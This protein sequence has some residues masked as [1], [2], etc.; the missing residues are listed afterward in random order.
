M[1]L[2][3]PVRVVVVDDNPTHLVSITNGLARAGVPC[4]SHWYDTQN[5]KLTPPAPNEGYPHLRVLFTDLNILEMTGASAEPKN[6]AAVLISE[7]LQPIVA[8]T[9]GPY[10]V[11]LWT[12]TGSKADDVSPLIIQRI[13]D[14]SLGTDRRPAP[15]LVNIVEKQAFIPEKNDA[16]DEALASLFRQSSE[17]PKIEESISRAILENA[18][19]RA[20]SSWE[21]RA[22]HA[23]AQTINNIYSVSTF[24]RTEERD[25]S[26][27]FQTILTKIAIEAAGKSAK[28]DPPRALDDGL[29]D[30]FI[31]K[32]QNSIGMQSYQDAVNAS[33]GAA[34]NVRAPVLTAESRLALNTSL[35]VEKIDL[36][37]RHIE[38]GL[39]IDINT[40]DALKKLE[41]GGR[42]KLLLDELIYNS[43]L[44]DA[45]IEAAKAANASASDIK[46]LQ[47]DLEF[48]TANKNQILNEARI[49]AIEIGADCDHAQRKDRTI[50][51]LLGAEIPSDF[52]RFI[53]GPRNRGLRSDALREFGPWDIEGKR[54]HL[55]VS[56]SR[57]AV[58]QSWLRKNE[59]TARY[60]LR[61]PL[62]DQLLHS[63]SNHSTRRGIIAIT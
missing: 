3:S 47:D 40:D 7:V 54:I 55:L 32:M 51:C 17:G 5:H 52:S 44:F 27:A 58:Q 30:L 13:D 1:E 4:V 10:S 41:L 49:V 62:V 11:C 37:G 8:P 59:L 19:L 24:E 56:L 38:R 28:Q 46:T 57:F 39:V 22:S 26:S 2:S 18:Q 15:L 42:R 61:K 35:H 29:A 63:Y 50:R 53:H 48:V 6:L 21:S 16:A 31:D 43:G 9:S 60:R 14:P 20:A 23:A 36:E 25:D 45:A 33:I 12:S 34:L